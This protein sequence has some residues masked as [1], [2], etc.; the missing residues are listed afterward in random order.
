MKDLFNKLWK[1]QASAQFSDNDI[2]RAF[3]DQAYGFIQNKAGK[4]LSDPHRLGFEIVY[5]ND[6]ST[7]MVGIFAFRAEKRLLYAP[8]FFI[9]GEIKGTDLLYQHDRKLFTPLT[10]EWANYLLKAQ[11][12]NQGSGYQG[13]APRTRSA[14][15]YKLVSPSQS[16]N[17]SKYASYESAPATIEPPI[18]EVLDEMFK[19]AELQPILQRFIL[20]DGGRHAVESIERAV[21]TNMKFARA[22]S[23]VDPSQYLPELPVEKKASTAPVLTLVRGLQQ[24]VKSAFDQA[25]VL[26]YGFTLLDDRH[27]L[28]TVEVD[29][30]QLESV[31]ESGVY[32]VLMADGSRQEMVCVVDDKGGCGSDEMRTTANTKCVDSKGRMSVR[33]GDPVYGEQLM[34]QNLE[35]Y[36]KAPTAGK[37]YLFF[38][39]QNPSRGQLFK[40]KSISKRG[41]IQTL[42]L[43]TEYGSER[44][45]TVNPD[46]KGDLKDSG[47]ELLAGAGYMWIPVK[48]KSTDYG[49][50]V[51]DGEALGT[52]QSLNR[53][54]EKSGSIR[55]K[56]SNH[57]DNGWSLK[58]LDKVVGKDLDVT[59]MAVKLARDLHI[60]ADH[61][62]G[63]LETAQPSVDFWMN[64]DGLRKSGSMQVMEEPDFEDDYDS[65]FGVPVNY[66]HAQS[67]E[68]S[69]P[70]EEL[71]QQRVGDT[72]DPNDGGG[73]P[74]EMLMNAS[75]EELAQYAEMNQLPNLF[76]HGIVGSMVKSF[77]SP[78]MLDRYMPDLEKALD[79]MGRSLFLLFWKP[80][81]FDDAWGPEERQSTEDEMLANFK[82]FGDMV[83]HLLHKSK[84]NR[85]VVGISSNATA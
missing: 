73:A 4:L 70:F 26:K 14:D 52:D 58:M 32:K 72:E 63:L 61:V 76:E 45:M 84:S 42:E 49:F 22:L 23:E 68:V 21:H 77:D 64:V 71:P 36:K 81:E 56:L 80:G 54:V 38:D 53:M 1:K 65:Q 75:P 33:R 10:E 39:A 55:L 46:L 51:E 18:S 50:D 16:N 19:R 78:A 35:K 13:D 30:L 40:V 31:A 41:D 9:N 2:E 7:R 3:M 83:L 60:G 85:G 12:M 20:E 59:S 47:D 62:F 17:F 44:T 8:S 24:G 74:H 67:L 57:P 48:T 34:D 11:N 5:K 66:G 37:T 43:E 28:N 82:S 25:R 29:D 27:D 6:N 69:T 15:L 79:S